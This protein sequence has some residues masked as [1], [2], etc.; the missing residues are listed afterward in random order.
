MNVVFVRPKER[1]KKG[2]TV[3]ELW[4]NKR[5]RGIISSSKTL[6]KMKNK[7]NSF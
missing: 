7:T 4:S 1:Q 6:Q 5:R 2:A 3:I